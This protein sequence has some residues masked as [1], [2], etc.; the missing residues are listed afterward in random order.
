MPP[1]VP[2]WVANP[3]IREDWRVQDFRQKLGKDAPCHLQ[4]PT[5]KHGLT[6]DEV[7]FHNLWGKQAQTLIS[8]TYQRT[9]AAS[10]STTWVPSTERVNFGKLRILLSRFLQMKSS[11]LPTILSCHFSQICGETTTHMW[12]WR[13]R[14]TTY[15]QANKLLSDC[16]LVGC[17]SNK[18]NDLSVHATRHIRLSW[19][20]DA[21]DRNGH[22][23]IFDVKFGKTSEKAVK[24]SRE[25]SAEQ[26][27]GDLESVASAVE[28]SDLG[29]TVDPVEPTASCINDT[30][31]RQL[32]TRS[33][34]PR[35]RC[36]VCHLHHKRA[37]NEFACCCSRIFQNS[38]STSVSFQGWCHCRRCQRRSIQVL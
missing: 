38:A 3:K 29:P 20:S 1:P 37:M 4:R 35:L 28:G 22:A 9:S 17:H 34:L 14:L 33:G 26:L 18:W 25:R 23:A 12:S 2:E 31:N 8:T 11:T 19:W 21:D 13:Q 6:V 36:G 10:S 27:F 32:A 24:E 5:Q 15:R 30:K 16:G 7:S